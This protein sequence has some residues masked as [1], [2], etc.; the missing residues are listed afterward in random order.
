MILQD[1]MPLAGS[2]KPTFLTEF[3]AELA[4]C[5]EW[6]EGTSYEIFGVGTYHSNLYYLCCYDRYLKRAWFIPVRED[7]MNSLFWFAAEDISDGYSLCTRLSWH[8]PSLPMTSEEAERLS[9]SCHMAMVGQV[10]HYA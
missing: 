9:G 7:G 1:I 2:I 8:L 4:R 5:Q 3:A 6:G 10:K